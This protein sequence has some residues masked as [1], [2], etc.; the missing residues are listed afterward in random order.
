L[1]DYLMPPE[2]TPLLIPLNRE[3]TWLEDQAIMS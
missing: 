3:G 1:R 2:A